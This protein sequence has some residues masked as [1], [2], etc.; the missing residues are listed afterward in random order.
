MQKARHFA[1]SFHDSTFECVA[2]GIEPV[3]EF[4]Q[5]DNLM[6]GIAGTQSIVETER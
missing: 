5:I 2:V 1:F 6:M 3:D 4:P